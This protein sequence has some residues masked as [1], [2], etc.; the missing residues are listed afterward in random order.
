[1]GVR[2]HLARL[3]ALGCVHTQRHLRLGA[4][5]GEEG[6]LSE[7]VARL[8]GGHVLLRAIGVRTHEGDLAR[9]QQAEEA[10]RLALCVQLAPRIEGCERTRR[11]RGV[12]G[13]AIRMRAEARATVP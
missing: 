7:K 9:E 3:G 1:M 2:T 4:E 6:V 12:G 11:G 5:G 10:R 8:D 13:T